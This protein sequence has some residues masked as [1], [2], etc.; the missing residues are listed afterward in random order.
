MQAKIFG[1][2]SIYYTFVAFKHPKNA[3]YEQEKVPY[4]QVCKNQENG[5]RKGVQLYKCTTCGHQFRA[6]YPV[7]EDQLWDAY[8]NGK[9]TIKELAQSYRVSESSI[10]RKLRNINHMWQQPDLTAMSTP[11]LAQFKKKN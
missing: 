6:G 2:S 11:K 1:K 3:A 8:L 10:K 4:L 5:Q 9:Q 7:L